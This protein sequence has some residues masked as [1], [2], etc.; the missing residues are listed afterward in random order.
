MKIKTTINFTHPENKVQ[1]M[2]KKKN[3]YLE[4]LRMNKDMRARARDRAASPA[5]YVASKLS[6]TC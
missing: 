2:K 6:K 3:K 1:R 5:R 4:I